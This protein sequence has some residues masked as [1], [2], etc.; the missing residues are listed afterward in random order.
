[1]EPRVIKFRGKRTDGAMNFVFGSLV[2]ENKNRSF[3]ISS[4]EVGYNSTLKPVAHLVIPNTVSQFTGHKDSNGDEIYEG[5]K[6]YDRMDGE[7]QFPETVAWDQINSCWA[8]YVDGTQIFKFMDFCDMEGYV[9]V[10]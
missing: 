3:I 10:K 2:T 5:D 7:E 8:I 9:I 1:M 6:I 4:F